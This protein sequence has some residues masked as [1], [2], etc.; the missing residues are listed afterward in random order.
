MKAKVL[1]RDAKPGG[2]EGGE[3]PMDVDQ[4]AV[5]DEDD[6][7]IQTG[8]GVRK[9]NVGLLFFIQKN[10]RIQTKSADFGV[11]GEAIHVDIFCRYR[12][13]TRKVKQKA[14]AGL[15]LYRALIHTIIYDV[16]FP[17]CY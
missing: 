12:S 14:E 16:C 8:R 11:T 5:A 13:P 6:A 3:T 1:R 17:F 9:K 7:G 10:L 15:T 4:D 2:G